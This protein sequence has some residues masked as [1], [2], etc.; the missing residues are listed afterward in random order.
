MGEEVEEEC[1]EEG[2]EGQ[3]EGRGEYLLPDGDCVK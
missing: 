1:E 3:V 2:D